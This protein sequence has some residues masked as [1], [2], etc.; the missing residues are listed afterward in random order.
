MRIQRSGRIV[1]PVAPDADAGDGEHCGRCGYS[2]FLGRDVVPG[3]LRA[4]QEEVEGGCRLCGR[5]RGAPSNANLRRP[6]EDGRWHARQGRA[7][8]AVQGGDAPGHDVVAQFNLVRPV[9][10]ALVGEGAQ[11]LKRH[12]IIRVL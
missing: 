6:E 12:Q 7:R 8:Q 3:G 1:P 11:Q 9:F 5:R 2:R 10:S 4:L